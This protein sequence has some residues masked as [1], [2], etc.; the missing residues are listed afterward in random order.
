MIK[1][2]TSMKQELSYLDKT[3]SAGAALNFQTHHRVKPRSLVS[4]T[5]FA[6][7][8]AVIVNLYSQLVGEGL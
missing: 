6:G 2:S 8:A 4:N 1:E 7:T 3:C 5:N